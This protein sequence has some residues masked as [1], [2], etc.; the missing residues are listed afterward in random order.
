L[1]RRKKKTSID[2]SNSGA[3]SAD[4]TEDEGIESLIQTQLLE[5]D[6]DDEKATNDLD[7]GS[8]KAAA[9]GYHNLETFQKKKLKQKL[10]KLNP[11]TMTSG[12]Y[13]SPP[14][15]PQRVPHPRKNLHHSTGLLQP[16]T[17]LL[18][19]RAHNKGLFAHLN[20]GATPNSTPIPTPNVKRRG[21]NALIQQYHQQQNQVCRM[22]AIK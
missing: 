5:D 2:S 9:G 16:S 7:S 18:P 20:P 11:S 8:S 6:S 10:K 12:P 4:K 22:F 13:P 17:P 19:R 14:P 15:G 3:S 1:L 21:L